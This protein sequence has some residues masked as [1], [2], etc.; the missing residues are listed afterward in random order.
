MAAAARTR[1]ASPGG[2]D[3]KHLARLLGRGKYELPLL[4]LLGGENNQNMPI[5]RIN[6][7]LSK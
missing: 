4:K 2:R 1:N 6:R 7:A 3:S 5:P